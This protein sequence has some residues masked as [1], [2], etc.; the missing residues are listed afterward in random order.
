MTESDTLVKALAD[1]RQRRVELQSEFD[2]VG[3][4]LA[5]LKLAE[6]ALAAIVEGAPLDAGALSLDADAGQTNTKRGA[7]RG[8]RGPRANSAKG[9]LKA[10]LQ[11]TGTQGLSQAE[12][13]SRLPDVA[14]GT[15]NSYLS[16]LVT[17]GEA[18][19]RGDFYTAGSAPD[20]E[21]TA[22]E[23][24]EAERSVPDDEVERDEAAE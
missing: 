5:K 10:L 23:E 2:R 4:E 18:V 17:S 20:V 1:V 12:I 6:K 22:G 11:D 21:D 16:L 13:S 19:R 8:P 14:A 9:R 3:A 7:G 24:D 15:L